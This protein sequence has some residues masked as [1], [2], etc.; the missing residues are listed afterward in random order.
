VGKPV[1]I[2]AF[3]NLEEVIPGKGHIPME[4]VKEKIKNLENIVE[5]LLVEGGNFDL[6]VRA[7]LA[8][9]REVSS[10][11]EKIR[12]IEGIEEVSSAIVVNV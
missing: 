8:N 7:R 3:V 6:T 12:Q 1:E 4:N 9:I 5:I 11:L 10:F 2:L